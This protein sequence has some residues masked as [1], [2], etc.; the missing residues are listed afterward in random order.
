MI[1]KN[2]NES[3]GMT[4]H[5]CGQCQKKQHCPLP[6]HHRCC[7]LNLLFSYLAPWPEEEE[8]PPRHD[9]I[10]KKESTEDLNCPGS[11]KNSF[12]RRHNHHTGLHCCQQSICAIKVKRSNQTF[13]THL[14][15]ASPGLW[16]YQMYLDMT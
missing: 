3:F 8:L 1:I 15:R 13:P 11:R 4:P 12:H 6:P 9:V 10:R 14:E 7:H 5:P 2:N 16:S